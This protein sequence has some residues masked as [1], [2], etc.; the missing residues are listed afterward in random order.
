MDLMQEIVQADAA[1]A[2]AILDA[3]LKRYAVLFPDWEILTFSV[4]KSEDRRVQ[5][6]RAIKVLKQ[7]KTPAKDK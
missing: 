4:H 6:N 3:V 7:L 1:T 2:A 5:I